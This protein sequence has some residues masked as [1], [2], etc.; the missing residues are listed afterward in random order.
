MCLCYC[1]QQQHMLLIILLICGNTV[2]SPFAF[3]RVF[4]QDDANLLVWSA[5]YGNTTW[6]GRT[7][8]YYNPKQIQLNEYHH[9]QIYGE[10]GM[11]FVAG[12]E[13]GHAVGLDEYNCSYEMMYPNFNLNEPY[14]G[15]I[16]GIKDL[17]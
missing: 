10:T 13:I 5:D 17:Y 2:Y 14:I 3:N 4:D 16:Q 15:D 7:Y 1:F 11:A 6:V 12:H 9:D 8:Y